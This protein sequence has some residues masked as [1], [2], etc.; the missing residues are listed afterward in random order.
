MIMCK[1]G[2][3]IFKGDVVKGAAVMSGGGFMAA[4]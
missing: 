1:Y 3:T 4:A 2:E